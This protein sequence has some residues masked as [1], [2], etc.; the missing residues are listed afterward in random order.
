MNCPELATEM[1][2]AFGAM[3]RMDSKKQMDKLTRGELFI[4]RY[5]KE[6]CADAVMPSEISAAMNISSAR[7]AV[8]LRTLEE[9][10]W[11]ERS[12]DNAD[13]R[14]MLVTITQ[15]GRDEFLFHHAEMQKKMEILLSEIGEEDIRE[16]IRIVNRMLEIF[17]TL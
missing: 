12:M 11:I 14:K 1:F 4:L 5:L 16:F 13:R 2:A 15:T 3:F 10:G 17:K 6:H 9:K 7:V 8:A